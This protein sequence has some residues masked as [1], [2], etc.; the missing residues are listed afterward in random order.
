LRAIYFHL[1]SNQPA[2]AALTEAGLRYARD[3]ATRAKFERARAS[4]S[5]AK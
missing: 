2:A 4:F 1:V 3:P 5:E